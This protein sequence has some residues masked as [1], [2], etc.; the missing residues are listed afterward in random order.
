MTKYKKYYGRS[1]PM[2]S[3]TGNN[4]TILD[5]LE[6]FTEDMPG[7]KLVQAIEYAYW[8]PAGTENVRYLLVEKSI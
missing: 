7:Y 1:S 2:D 8:T 4:P 5:M 3:F 6:T